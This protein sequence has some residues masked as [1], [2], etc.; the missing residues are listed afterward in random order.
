MVI[1]DDDD[2]GRFVRSAFIGAIASSISDVVPGRFFVDIGEW[3]STK[4]AN[5]IGN[6]GDNMG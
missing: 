3:D 1:H 5:F 2:W 6:I 4:T